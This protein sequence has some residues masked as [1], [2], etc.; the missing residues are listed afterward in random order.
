MSEATSPTI[1]VKEAVLAAAMPKPILEGAGE[2]YKYLS[3]TKLRIASIGSATIKMKVNNI[4][5]EQNN[6][7]PATV[8]LNR[9]EGGEWTPL[10]T[11]TLGSDGSSTSYSATTPGFSIFAIT[12]EFK[13]ATAPVAAPQPAAPEPAAPQT[14]AQEPSGALGS[15]TGAVVA[16][17]GAASAKVGAMVVGVIIVAG[18]IVIAML[19]R[20]RKKSK[21]A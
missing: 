7:D 6:I 17:Q 21:G 2:V 9:L 3:I 20:F 12:G 19:G 11:I 14:A 16:G 10:S 4:W 18:L 13:A 15:I 8:R 5:M 1:S